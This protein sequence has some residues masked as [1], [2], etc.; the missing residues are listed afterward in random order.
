MYLNSNNHAC[1]AKT[2]RL[3]R[4]ISNLAILDSVRLL[5]FHE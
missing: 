3:L 2:L 1:E 5:G 4:I